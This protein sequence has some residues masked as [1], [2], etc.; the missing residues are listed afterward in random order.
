MFIIWGFVTIAWF[1]YRQKKDYV[2]YEEAKYGETIIRK[3]KKRPVNKYLNGRSGLKQK[4][5]NEFR[6]GL[7]MI[8]LVNVLLLTINIIDIITIWF[9]FEYTPHFDLK[10]FVH[11]GT[12]LL[13]LSILLSILIMVW[14]FRKNINFFPGK[15]QLQVL[16]YIW[17]VQ[18]LILLVSVIIRNLHYIEYFGLAYKRIGVFLFLSLVVFG[19]ITLYIKIKEI[20]STFFLIRLNSWA[21]YIGFVLFAMPDWDIII[22]KHNLQHPFKNNIETSYLLTLD[23]KALPLID[24]RKDILKQSEQYNTY[25]YFYDSYENVYYDRVDHF[26]SSYPERSVFSWNLADEKAYEYFKNK[27]TK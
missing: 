21:V 20:K 15:K 23:D 24:Q 22:A 3:R 27:S 10:Q 26:T 8:I 1:I 2:T 13:T 5:K 18:N 11:E 7:I 9:G 19:L 4:L 17:I 25:R 6:I 14:F 16:S 12:Y